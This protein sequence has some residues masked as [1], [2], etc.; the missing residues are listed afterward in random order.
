VPVT[1]AHPYRPPADRARDA[2]ARLLGDIR[3]LGQRAAAPD[4]RADDRGG[5]DVP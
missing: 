2:L 1:T 4:G 5:Q 3:G